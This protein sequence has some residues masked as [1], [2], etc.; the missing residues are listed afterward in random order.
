MVVVKKK[1][2]ETDENLIRRF[3]R[4]LQQSRVLNQ[5]RNARFRKKKKTKRELIKDA[6][7]R[8]KMKKAIDK[9]KKMDCFDEEKLKDLKKKIADK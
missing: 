1:E 3:T 7:Y 8:Q 9:L 4:T 6:V 5:A 2:R